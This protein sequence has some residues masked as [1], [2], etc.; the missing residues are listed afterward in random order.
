VIAEGEPRK[1]RRA[2]GMRRPRCTGLG[3]APVAVSQ[4]A[5]RDATTTTAATL[6]QIVQYIIGSIFALG[7]LADTF[8]Q[9]FG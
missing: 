4:W 1:H 9:I 2:C 8:R 6:P 5:V 7:S 3:P